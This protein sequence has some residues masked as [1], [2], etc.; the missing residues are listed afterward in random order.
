MTEREK[1]DPADALL[2]IID[3]GPDDAV[4]RG[5]DDGAGT[6]RR[7]RGPVV[8]AAIVV[9]ALVAVTI[10]SWTHHSSS[11]ASSTTTDAS[12]TNIDLRDQ[13]VQASPL[14]PFRVGVEL[15]TGGT[16]GLRLVDTETGL[17]SIPNVTGL[18]LGPVTVVAHSGSTVAVRAAAHLYWFTMTVGIAHRLDA[19]AAFASARPG[20]LWFASQHFATEVPGDNDRLPRTRVATESLAIGATNRG[21]LIATKAGVLLQPGDASTAHLFLR[22]PATVIAVHPDRVAWISG[23]CSAVDC[24]VTV[25]M[26]ATGATSGTIDLVGRPSP[27]AVAETSGVFSPDGNFLAVV[28]PDDHAVRA[29]LLNVADLRTL[30]STSMRVDG[31]FEQPAP[32]GTSDVTGMTIDWTLDSTFLVLGTAPEVGSD[33]IDVMDPKNPIVVSADVALGTGTSA[34]VIGPSSVKAP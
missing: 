11:R 14:F 7:R 32:P 15:L 33:R 25:T 3:L 19:D 22:A 9:A 28:V 2:Q 8:F 17:A 27:F 26:I 20:H 31:T 18:P 10:A 34:A 29:Q 13:A 12:H 1:R 24:A 6:L 23:E 21:L 5:Y 30:A 16:T 4:S